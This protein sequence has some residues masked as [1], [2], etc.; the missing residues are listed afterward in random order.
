MLPKKPLRMSLRPRT[1]QRFQP[2]VQPLLIPSREGWPKAGV[3][4]LHSRT[5]RF[6]QPEAFSRWSGR[7][8]VTSQIL[9]EA[10]PPLLSQAK[11]PPLIPSLE[12]MVPGPLRMLILPKAQPLLIPSREGW[13]KAGVGLLPAARLPFPME[14]PPLGLRSVPLSAP[15]SEQG[16]VTVRP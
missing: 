5:R 11:P 12:G 13:P 14:E 8:R 9:P 1:L 3:G 7:I 4:L 15:R 10:G 16:A 2:V 6:P